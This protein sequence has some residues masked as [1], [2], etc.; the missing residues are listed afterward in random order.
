MR[1]VLIV[2]F[3]GVQ[4]LDVTGPLEVFAGANRWQCGR[5]PSPAVTRGP[6]GPAYRIRTAS[7][8]GRPVRT[9]SG[10]RLA[11]D[12][13]LGQDESGPDVL[14]VP[15]G[16]GTRDADPDLVAWL[17]TDRAPAGIVAAMRA[18]SRFILTGS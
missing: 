17:S 14:L 10:L 8:G 13:S 2:L 3:D 7:L 18:R 6:D 11:P 15:G 1:T 16:E 4:S 9:S 5:D 12:E